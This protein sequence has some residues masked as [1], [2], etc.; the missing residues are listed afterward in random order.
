MKVGKYIEPLQI[1]YDK[2]YGVVTCGGQSRG[3]AEQICFVL[4]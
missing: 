3:N 1:Y 4:L 2:Q